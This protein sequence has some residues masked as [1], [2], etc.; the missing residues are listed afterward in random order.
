MNLQTCAKS[1]AGSALAVLIL[2]LQSCA[3][4]VNLTVRTVRV[5]APLQ[6]PCRAPDVAAPAW[7]AAVLRKTY[8]LKMKVRALTAERLL[9][10]TVKA[11]R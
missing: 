6:V 3:A 9:K 11:C 1:Q 5:E 8:S 4:R 10:T 2:L 7:A